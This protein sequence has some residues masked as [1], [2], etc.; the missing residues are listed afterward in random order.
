MLLNRAGG[1]EPPVLAAVVVISA[2]VPVHWEFGS[3]EGKTNTEQRHNSKLFAGINV[4]SGGNQNFAVKLGGFSSSLLF[5][6][7]FF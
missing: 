4:L 1:E 5:F 7:Y 2:C 3:P 6:S